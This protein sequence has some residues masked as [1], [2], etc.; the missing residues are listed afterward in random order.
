M[1]RYSYS[2]LLQFGSRV[3][4]AAGSS[5]DEAAIVADGLLQADARGVSSHGYTRL[6]A[7]AER[8]KRGIVRPDVR[9]QLLRDTSSFV[10][11]DGGN[12]MD[13]AIARQAMELCVERARTTGCCFAS[14]TNANHFGIGANYTLQAVKAGMVGLAM[15]NAPAS[16]VPI[17][18][19]IP[20]LGTNPFA[21][22]VPAGRRVPFCLDMATSVVAQGK[23]I[24]AHKQGAKTIPEGWAVD[25]EGRATTDPAAA[26][27]G[28]M[29][30]FGGAKGYGIALMIDLFC[31][32]LAGAHTGTTIKSFWTDFQEPQGLGI[33][34]GVWNLEVL[35]ERDVVLARVDALLDDIKSTPPTDG[36]DEVF[37][38][39]EL[40]HRRADQAHR[41]GI[42][43]DP[44]VS[45]QINDL[46]TAYGIEPPLSISTR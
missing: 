31:G 12:G 15:S 1:P 44:T 43:F 33:F 19:R 24:L 29:L 46:A 42:D 8:V 13:I 34:L 37:Y 6:G 5:A 25:S 22:A 3:L 36:A 45:R 27:K 30:P 9:L 32:A 40:E 20:K 18:G 28:A 39:G 38:A 11:I 41:D 17:G 21:V 16:T 23:V 4:Q 10:H 7:Y 14:I 2:N 35:G 26:L